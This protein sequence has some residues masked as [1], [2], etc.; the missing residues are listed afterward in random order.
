MAQDNQLGM[1]RSA[2]LRRHRPSI[3]KARWIMVYEMRL[4]DVPLQDNGIVW[5]WELWD[6]EDRVVLFL[7]ACRLSLSDVDLDTWNGLQ[8]SLFELP[9]VKWQRGRPSWYFSSD[10]SLEIHVTKRLS[11][12]F[13]SGFINDE[14]QMPVTRSCTWQRCINK[15]GVA[16]MLRIARAILGFLP[17]ERAR[18]WSF[19]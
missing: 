1:G 16:P 9:R 19:H 18:R 15:K 11:M 7:H 4:D 14:W 17:L 3:P 2:A 5:W 10:S 13:L 8:C 6:D 12:V